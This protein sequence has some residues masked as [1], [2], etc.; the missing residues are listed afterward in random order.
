MGKTMSICADF[1]VVAAGGMGL[2]RAA[3]RWMSRA[4][5]P[6]IYRT[7]ISCFFTA[8][9]TLI[10]SETGLVDSFI[11]LELAPMDGTLLPDISRVCGDAKHV[12]MIYTQLTFPRESCSMN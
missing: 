12:H 5:L 2:K 9:I 10:H 8:S 1:Q 3:V 7:K 11:S 6:R 4:D